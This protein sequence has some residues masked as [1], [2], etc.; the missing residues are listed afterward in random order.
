MHTPLGKRTSSIIL[1]AESFEKDVVTS[2]KVFGPVTTALVI[3]NDELAYIIK[4]GKSHADTGVLIK[5]VTKTLK[6]E[7]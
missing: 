3:S 1:G 2:E 7:A 4:I 6:N 5:R